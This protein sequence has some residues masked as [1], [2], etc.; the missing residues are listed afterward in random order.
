PGGA[1]GRA[2]SCFLGTRGGNADRRALPEDRRAEGIL[3]ADRGGP[4]P[5][6][7]SSLARHSAGKRPLD[8]TLGAREVSGYT[9]QLVQPKTKRVGTAVAIP[10]EFSRRFATLGAEM[11]AT[12]EH[13]RK[14]RPRRDCD[15]LDEPHVL[16][17]SSVPFE[18]L[19][20]LSWVGLIFR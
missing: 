1:S 13:E 9:G 12:G 11:R 6:I 10:T 18:R 19:L 4:E 14:E 3:L 15:A 2:P 7:S 17:P 5:R 20:C 16:P 8:W